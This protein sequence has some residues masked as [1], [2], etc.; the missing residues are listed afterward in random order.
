MK[1]ANR[2]V[3]VFIALAMP[4]LQ[5]GALEKEYYTDADGVI[6]QYYQL[7]GGK[8]ANITQIELPSGWNGDLAIPAKIAGLSVVHIGEDASN[9]FSK[10]KPGGTVSI[11]AGV[12]AILAG[13]FSGCDSIEAFEVDE[14]N[15][16]LKSSNGCVTS[17]DGTKLVAVPDGAR[18]LRIPDGVAALGDP[19]LF[20]SWKCEILILPESLETIACENLLGWMWNLDTVIFLGGVPRGFSE[21]TLLDSSFSMY[22]AKH[23]CVLEEHLA[24]WQGVGFPES[25]IAVENALPGKDALTSLA[26]EAVQ[27]GDFSIDGAEPGRSYALVAGD[28][29]ADLTAASQSASFL[30][31]ES[32]HLAFPVPESSANAR[33]FKLCCVIE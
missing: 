29:L 22:H 11:P 6:W 15:T 21:H 30:R 13:V 25:G 5:L 3:S 28:N 2:A 10:A 14:A 20:S 27:S 26:F 33:F 8:L 24:E 17:R 32:E 19:V 9:I 4:C 23:V 7:S 12:E 18:I 1:I 31:A 16:F